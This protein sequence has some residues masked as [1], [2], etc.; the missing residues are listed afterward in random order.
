MSNSF[1][2]EVLHVPWREPQRKRGAWGSKTPINSIS[3]EI[4]PLSVSYITQKKVGIPSASCVCAF[5][6]KFWFAIW[7]HS[8]MFLHK[9][10]LANYHLWRRF[11]ESWNIQCFKFWYMHYHTVKK[12]INQV[13]QIWYINKKI[14]VAVCRLE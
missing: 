3:F 9:S 2:F 8:H 13:Y 7:A 4:K 5:C 11:H 1:S 10:T 6:F 12:N 14:S